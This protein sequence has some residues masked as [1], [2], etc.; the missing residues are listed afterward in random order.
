MAIVISLLLFMILSASITLYGYRRYVRPARYYDQLGGN[1]A[2]VMP[3]M[4]KI[5]VDDEPGLLVKV[6]HTVGEKIP[7]SPADAGLTRRDLI[8]AGY[9]SE[10]AVTIFQGARILAT[11]F[12]V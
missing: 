8:A 6:L 12:L 2:V 10:S 7:P 9:R 4:D 1:A 3:G 5:G 11:A